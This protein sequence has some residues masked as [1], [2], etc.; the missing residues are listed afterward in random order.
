MKKLLILPGFSF[1]NKEWML[2]ARDFLSGDFETTTYEWKHW[3]TGNEKDFSFEYEIQKVSELL[4]K[5]NFLLAKSIGTLVSAVA[6]Y[7]NKL[8]LEKILFC[9]VPLKYS[10]EEGRDCYNKFFEK[11][12]KEQ[13]LCFQNKLDPFGTYDEIKNLIHLSND[14]L[15]I[16]KT[17]REDHSYPFYEDFRKYFLKGLA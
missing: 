11:L 8:L 13:F 2:E 17:D 15:E 7:K 12:V 3:E 14:K 9:G 10:D 4:K 16:V 1:K 5:A 6:I